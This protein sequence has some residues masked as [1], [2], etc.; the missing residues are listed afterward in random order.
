MKIVITHVG[1]KYV[2]S[3]VIN[4][5]YTQNFTPGPCVESTAV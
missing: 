3:A 2:Q 5:I 1:K 4:A